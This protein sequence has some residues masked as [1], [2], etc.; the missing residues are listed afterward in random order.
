MIEIRMLIEERPEGGIQFEVYHRGTDAT[1]LEQE[2]VQ[3]YTAAIQCANEEWLKNQGGGMC[4][5]YDKKPK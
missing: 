1:P 2:R 4:V 3:A 5:H